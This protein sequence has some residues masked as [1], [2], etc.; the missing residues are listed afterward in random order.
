MKID[1]TGKHKIYTLTRR[2]FLNLSLLISA[3]ASSWGI[4]KFLSYKAPEERL[5]SFITLNQ[6]QAYHLGSV[7]YIREVKAWLIHDQ[8][9]FYALS[10]TCTHLGCTINLGE[11]RF[12]CPCHG[13]Q[14]DLAGRVLKGPAASPLPGYQVRL[15]DD[16]RIVID[17]RV[18]VPPSQRL[19]I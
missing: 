5:L 7:T 17:R 12:D 15:S 3:A 13:S 2:A 11:E 10:S 1:N 18:S 16:G 6:P 4:I 9:G 14:F 8:E 19:D